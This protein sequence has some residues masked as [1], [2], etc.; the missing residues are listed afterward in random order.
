MKLL[1]RYKIID[2]KSEQAVSEAVGFIIIFSLVMIGIGLVTLYGYPIL[3]QQQTNANVRNMERDMI[4]IQN[5]LK[6]LVYKNVPYKE[7][8][9]QI[10]GGSLTIYNNSMTTSYFQIS[11]SNGTINAAISNLSPN[12]CGQFQYVSDTSN[13][14]IVLENGAVLYRQGYTS[15]STML[16][17]PRFYI[18][19]DP[20]SGYKTFV[21]TFINFTSSSNM[22]KNGVGTVKMRVIS[23]D[24]YS[25]SDANGMSVDVTYTPDSKNDFSRAWSN[26]L[27]KPPLSLSESGNMYTLTNV[28]TLTIK[29]YNIRIEGI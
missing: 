27:T 12:Y 3:L 13:E 10:S 8:S 29:R 21:V 1:D 25:Y 28:N 6:S 9:L 17:E 23:S 26:Y 20:I 5:D 14:V 22:S 7:T 2:R 4:I 19:T 18:D 11:A 15:G 24:Y 16:A